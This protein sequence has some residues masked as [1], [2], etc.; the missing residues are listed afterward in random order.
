MY[1][2]YPLH[3]ILN[4]AVGGNYF[5]VWGP[6]DPGA[7]KKDKNELYD[8]SLFP[9][10]MQIDWVRVYKKNNSNQLKTKI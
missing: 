10:T 6:N 8:F 4:L 9:Q 2:E 3:I 5:G 1:Q 7:D